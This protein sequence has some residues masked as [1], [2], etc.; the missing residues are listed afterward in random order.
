MPIHDLPKY[1]DHG[2]IVKLVNR[3][4]IE[5]AQEESRYAVTPSTCREGDTSNHF[6]NNTDPELVSTEKQ[7]S[8]S[9]CY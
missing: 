8:Q 1:G 4:G 3:Y 5:M 7:S 9:P 6:R 2:F